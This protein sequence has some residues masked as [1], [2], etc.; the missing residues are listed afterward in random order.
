MVIIAP[1]L[2]DLMF[3]FK[4]ERTV[5]LCKKNHCMY[6][7]IELQLK[8]PLKNRGAIFKYSA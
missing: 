8:T 2:L 3:V 1:S 5:S 4:H 6:P 7:I